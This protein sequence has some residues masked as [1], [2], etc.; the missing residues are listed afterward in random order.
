[1][2]TSF[3]YC[4]E[5]IGPLANARILHLKNRHFQDRLAHDYSQ[6]FHISN[7]FPSFSPI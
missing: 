3:D 5:I 6:K 1:M 7:D 4:L 2:S